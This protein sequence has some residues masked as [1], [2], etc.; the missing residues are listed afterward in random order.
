MEFILNIYN[1][2]TEIS[3]SPAYSTLPG[4]VAIIFSTLIDAY[5]EKYNLSFKEI[6]GMLT[7]ILGLVFISYDN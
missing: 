2:L 4:V 1:V 3:P 6:S 5:A 7:I